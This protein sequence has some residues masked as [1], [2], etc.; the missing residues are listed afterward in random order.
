MDLFPTPDAQDPQKPA[1]GRRQPTGPLADAIRA[2]DAA[3]L[4][5]RACRYVWSPKDATLMAK[6]L[7]MADGSVGGVAQRIERLLDDEDAW[8]ARNASPGLLVSRWNQL[9][10]PVPKKPKVGTPLTYVP[11]SGPRIPPPANLM[12]QL[13]EAREA[14]L[15]A[16]A[17]RTRRKLRASSSLELRYAL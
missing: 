16:T 11:V 4:R 7:R 13:R 12:E 1:Q 17:A 2:W 9:A 6:A 5:A 10:L 14:A 3:W 15:R 8:V